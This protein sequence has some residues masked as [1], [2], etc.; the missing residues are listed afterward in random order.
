MDKIG[1][2]RSSLGTNFKN[3]IRRSF[4]G[5]KRDPGQSRAKFGQQIIFSVLVGAIFNFIGFHNEGGL[6]GKVTAAR[7]T[8]E[9]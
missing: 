4:I 8:P 6:D 1:S 2:K 7:G 3:L 9:F 5:I